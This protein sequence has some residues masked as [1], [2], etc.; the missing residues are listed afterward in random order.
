MGL[1]LAI[2]ALLILVRPD[3]LLESRRLAALDAGQNSAEAAASAP[4]DGSVWNGLRVILAR[5]VARLGLLALAVGHSVMVSVMVM[6]PLHMAHGH[7]E[8]SIIG[9]VISMHILGMFAFAPLTGLAVD[10]FGGRAVAVVGSMI[11]TTATLLASVSPIGHS[12]TL[13][14]GLFLPIDPVFVVHTGIANN[15]WFRLLPQERPA[16]QGAA[17]VITGLAAAISGFLG[18]IIVAHLSFH[19]LSLTSLGFA[20][21]IGIAAAFTPVDRDQG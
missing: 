10:R 18:G 19:A 15:F 5:P 1:V 7:A 17:D 2:A 8:L 14:I 13:L 20:L 4:A 11:L 12:S 21:V 6:T 3:P 9:F 16:A